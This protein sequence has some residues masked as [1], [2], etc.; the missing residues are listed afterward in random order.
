MQVCSTRYPGMC[1]LQGGLAQQVSAIGNTNSFGKPGWSGMMDSK[2]GKGGPGIQ[3]F[4][5]QIQ[6]DF[7]F[8]ETRL[9]EKRAMSSCQVKV[10]YIG[11]MGCSSHACTWTKAGPKPWRGMQCMRI[12]YLNAAGVGAKT[13]L[14]RAGWRPC[15]DWA[16]TREN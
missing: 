8:L 9:R 5:D 15:G 11:H 7:F 13:C 6:V 14:L 3:A 16:G 1:H 10:S 4:M 12:E 2:L